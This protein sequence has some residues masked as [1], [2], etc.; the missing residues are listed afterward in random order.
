MFGIVLEKIM[1]H[2]NSIKSSDNTVND[3]TVWNIKQALSIKMSSLLLKSLK[4]SIG[5]GNHV[6]N[7]ID[8]CLVQCFLRLAS[9]LTSLIFLTL[10]NVRKIS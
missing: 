7:I 6:E 4:T 5:P 3:I 10:S 2:A 8:E 9:C 1:T